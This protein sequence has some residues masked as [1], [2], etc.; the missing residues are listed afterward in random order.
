MKIRHIF[1][2]SLRTVSYNK[3]QNC[4]NILKEPGITKK[5]CY[6]EYM[7]ATL[8]I[9]LEFKHLMNAMIGDDGYYLRSHYD[10]HKVIWSPDIPR[11]LGAEC[12]PCWNQ[13]LYL[14]ISL[15]LGVIGCHLST[16]KYVFILSLVSWRLIN[17]IEVA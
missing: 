5:K 10:C 15:E 12:R 1:K 11:L 6:C 4:L 17:V 13:F 16:I 14:L 7:F 9:S 3:R 8:S 2:K